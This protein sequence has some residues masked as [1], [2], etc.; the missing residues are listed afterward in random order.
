[1]GEEKTEYSGSKIFFLYPSASVQNLI[2][3]EL[4]KNEYEVYIAK[5]HGRLTYVLSKYS[6]SVIFINIDDK[7]PA[8]E[9][10]KWIDDAVQTAPTIRIGIFTANN[11]DALR[12][13]FT[14]NNQ[15]KCGFLVLKYD[16]SKTTEVIM[17]MMNVMNVKGRRKFLRITPDRDT[18][19]SINI[20]LGGEFLNGVI[21]DISVVGFS[22]VFNNNPVLKKS[23]LL[24]DIQIKL[25]S[26]LLNVEAVVFGSRD[27]ED[28]KIYVM[29]FTHR[30]DME[31]RS[32]KIRS[33]IQKNLQLRMDAEIN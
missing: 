15:I 8:E 22:C 26:M 24:K 21:K 28:E 31:T 19:A 11:D 7:M 33:Y 6:D 5:D 23:T 32:S 10:E 3:T 2:I 1:M 18:I 17:E 12:E 20:P 30:I 4:A 27:H 14:K 9:W 29:L 25:Q 16:L 13:K